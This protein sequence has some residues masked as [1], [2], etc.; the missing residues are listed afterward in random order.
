MQLPKAMVRM[1]EIQFDSLQ[2]QKAID[3]INSIDCNFIF[4]TFFDRLIFDRFY[5][6]A[7]FYSWFTIKYLVQILI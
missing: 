5:P 4:D 2:V 1:D 6:P 3:R 7:L